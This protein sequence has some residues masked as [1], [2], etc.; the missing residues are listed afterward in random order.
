MARGIQYFFMS[1]FH[2]FGIDAFEGILFIIFATLLIV[3][4]IALFVGFILLLWICYNFVVQ[5][6]QRFKLKEDI[7]WLTK[8]LDFLHIENMK[9]RIRILEN[10][11]LTYSINNSSSINYN[12]IQEQLIIS[13]SCRYRWN[14][15]SAIEE[16]L[17]NKF[18]ET[19][20]GNHL[21]KGCRAEYL[22]VSHAVS[23]FKVIIPKEKVSPKQLPQM[24]DFCQNF[25]SN[26]VS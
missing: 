12:I 3:L 7:D 15:K 13:I 1:L 20:L 18:E 9:D 2:A 10:N 21:F 14:Y 22:P 8:T 25:L 26:A 6:I 11:V 19:I 5:K 4:I 16:N 17:K 23:I 24:I